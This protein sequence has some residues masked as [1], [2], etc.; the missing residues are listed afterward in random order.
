MGE[1]KRGR[2]RERARAR[3]TDSPSRARRRRRTRNES[4]MPCRGRATESGD[5][6]ACARRKA[7]EQEEREDRRGD[8]GTVRPFSRTRDYR[9]ARRAHGLSRSFHSVRRSGVTF[10]YTVTTCRRESRSA[11]NTGGGKKKKKNSHGPAS[12]ENRRGRYPSARST[13]P[14]SSSPPSS[15]RDPP[16][17]RR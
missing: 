13:L 5:W 4:G 2:S 6:L 7:R 15:P 11:N 8:S 3:E 12:P 14:R 16:R 9:H 17:A 10:R 1:R